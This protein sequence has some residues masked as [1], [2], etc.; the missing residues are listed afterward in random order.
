MLTLRMVAVALVLLLAAAIYH[1]PDEAYWLQEDWQDAV[2][3]GRDFSF[4]LFLGDANGLSQRAAGPALE[5][6]ESSG[7]REVS[8]SEAQ[9]KLKGKI[10]PPALTALVMVP[11]ETDLELVAFERL[12]SLVVMTFAY[13]YGATILSIPGKGHLFFSVATRYS[14]AGNDSAGWKLTRKIANLPILREVAGRLGSSGRWR[15]IDFSHHV[16]EADVLDWLIAEGERQEVK[17]RAEMDRVF[18]TT[19]DEW[20][21]SSDRS[22]EFLY[23]WASVVAKRQPSR[24]ERLLA[25]M[26]RAEEPEAVAAG[27]RTSGET[28]TERA[29]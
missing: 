2:E 25:A 1:S 6:V 11:D 10:L 14:R 9:D 27:E 15:V 26:A 5:K 23:D 24:M 12:S 29:R 8:F 22:L 13:T 3:L 28:T 16:T 17:D 7:F 20:L 4:L 21:A 19:P 18:G